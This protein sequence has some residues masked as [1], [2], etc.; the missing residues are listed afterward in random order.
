[1]LLYEMNY[2]FNEDHASI[3]FS[4]EV[5]AQYNTILNKFDVEQ[6]APLDRSGGYIKVLFAYNYKF[7]GVRP[8]PTL[9]LRPIGK[10]NAETVIYLNANDNGRILGPFPSGDYSASITAIAAQPGKKNVPVSIETNKARELDFV[11]TPD[12]VIRGCVTTSLKPEDKSVGMP[13]Y[14]YRSADREII[15]EAI[16]LKGSGIHRILRQTQ[17]EDVNNYDYLIARNDFCYNTCFGFFGLPAGD[18]QL[19]INAEGYKP[20]VKNYSVTPGTLEYFR[21]TEL[22][23]VRNVRNQ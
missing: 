9:I 14:R 22:T 17:G 5:L 13:D 2:A 15:I 21:I 10:K 7:D 6:G 1:M 16:S 20:I 11:F 23:P 3:L 4:R 8:G 19:S 12:G 18:Y